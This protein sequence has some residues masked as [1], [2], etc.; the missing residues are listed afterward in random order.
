MTG[1]DADRFL[2]DKPLRPVENLYRGT[3]L[4]TGETPAGPRIT[5]VRQTKLAIEE[6]I[7]FGLGTLQNR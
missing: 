6:D 1:I 2:V 5:C 3:P 7:R 4:A